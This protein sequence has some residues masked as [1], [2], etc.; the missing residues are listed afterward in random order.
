L[1]KLGSRAKGDIY[2]LAAVL[3]CGFIALQVLNFIP[4]SFRGLANFINPADMIA[5]L[6]SDKTHIEISN[7]ARFTAHVLI[8]VYLAVSFLAMW[9]AGRQHRSLALWIPLAFISSVGGLIWL[10]MD[11]I[12]RKDNQF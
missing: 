1:P 9:L 10:L 6:E 4:R 3:V 8:P 2:F 12:P 7:I 5:A 11:Q